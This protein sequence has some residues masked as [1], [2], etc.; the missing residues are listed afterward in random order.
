MKAVFEAVV[1]M[2]SEME[3]V[4]ANEGTSNFVMPHIQQAFIELAESYLMEEKW[5]SEKYVPSYEEYKDNGVLSSTLPLQ[6]ISFLGMLGNL[7]TKEV[8]DW[9]S[10]NPKIVRAF[11][12]IG[13]LIDDMATHKFEQEREHVASGVEC[14]MKHNGVSVEEAY[15]IINNDLKTYWKDMN[16]ECLNNP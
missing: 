12:L 5:C 8:F 16:E 14:Y 13:R 4:T 6:M 3:M 1:E 15:Q 9:I 2:C 7:T 11:S 10:T